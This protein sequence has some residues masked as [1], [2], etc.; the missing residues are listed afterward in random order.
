[1]R[2]PTSA[3]LAKLLLLFASD[4]RIEISKEIISWTS[5]QTEQYPV[6][7]ELSAL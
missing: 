4:I 1:M 7:V 5:L 3:Y 2:N 6:S